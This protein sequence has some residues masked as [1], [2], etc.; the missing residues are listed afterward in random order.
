MRTLALAA[1]SAALLA[2][3]TATEG[4]RDVSPAL[5]GP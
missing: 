3:I 5:W 1:T 4:C 2:S